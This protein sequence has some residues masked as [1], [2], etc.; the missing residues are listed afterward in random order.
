M[1]DPL[2]ALDELFPIPVGVEMVAEA[3]VGGGAGFGRP[4][5]EVHIGFYRRLT[6]LSPVAG[7]AGGHDIGPFV[8]AP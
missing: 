4:L 7:W 8:F 3:V 6:P 2:P 1:A 5:L